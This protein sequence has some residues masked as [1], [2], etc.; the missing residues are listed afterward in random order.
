MIK[1]DSEAI[2]DKMLDAQ[3]GNRYIGLININKKV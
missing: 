1:I 2:W 3:S